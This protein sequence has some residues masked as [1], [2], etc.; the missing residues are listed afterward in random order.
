VVLAYEHYNKAC[1]RFS[2]FPLNI[3]LLTRFQTNSEANIILKKLKEGK[4][5]LI[6]GT[7]RLLGESIE[8]KDL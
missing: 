2:S 6:I 8:Y 7:H 1:E 3:E 5:D 4:I